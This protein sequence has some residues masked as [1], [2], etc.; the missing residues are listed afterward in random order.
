MAPTE[1]PFEDQL[2]AF[3][4]RLTQWGL[5]AALELLNDRTQFRYT[6]LHA[7]ANRTVRPL[8]VFD[9]FREDRAYVRSAFLLEALCRLTAENGEFVCDDCRIDHRLLTFGAPIVSYFGMALGPQGGPTVAILCHFDVE[10]RA[11]KP[12]ELAFL[13]AVAPLLLEHL[14]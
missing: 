6:A 9:R 2:L 13:R 1:I 10:H 12:C 5:P 4:A 7:F 11:L 8:C 3:N 14:D